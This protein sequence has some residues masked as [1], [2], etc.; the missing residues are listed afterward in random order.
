MYFLIKKRTRTPKQK[1]YDLKKPDERSGYSLGTILK[2]KK[3]KKKD[4]VFAVRNNLRVLVSEELLF[5]VSND[6]S[7]EKVTM[8]SLSLTARNSKKYGI[9]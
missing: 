4:I 8:D 3:K 7:S 5:K 1:T 2:K 6:I 9:F